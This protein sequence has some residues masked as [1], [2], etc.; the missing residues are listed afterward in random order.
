MSPLNSGRYFIKSAGA[1]KFVGR[2]RVEDRSL[3]PKRVIL[4]AEDGETPVF[5][6]KDQGKT[7]E[8]VIGGGS[9]ASINDKVSAVLMPEEPA[10]QW[11]IEEVPQSGSNKYLIMDSQ[12]DGGWVLPDDA[13]ET[14]LVVRPL[15]ATKSLPP[16]Y[17]PNQVWEIVPVN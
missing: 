12:K 13:P 11:I 4:R 10:Q 16:Q 5:E 15:I 7:F 6:L 1:D 9:A 8:I 14:Q 2:A 3:N 17:P